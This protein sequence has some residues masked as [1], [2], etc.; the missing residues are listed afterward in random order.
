MTQAELN[1]NPPPDLTALNISPESQC[2]VIYRRLLRGSAT[3]LELSMKLD[4]IILS[5]TKRL[6]DLREKLKP[7]GWTIETKEVG[8]GIY[9]NTLERINQPMPLRQITRSQ[10]DA[11]KVR[12]RLD[13]SA[14]AEKENQC[15]NQ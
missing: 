14:P 11:S 2:G 4:R 5:H 9:E 13:S 6:C 10:P 8:H 15:L 12:W 1:F 7:L 3:G